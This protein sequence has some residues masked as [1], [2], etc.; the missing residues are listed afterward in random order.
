MRTG[1]NLILDGLLRYNVDTVIGIPGGPTVPFLDRLSSSRVKWVNGTNEMNAGFMA[2]GWSRARGTPGVICVTSGPGLAMTVNPVKNAF[3]E[4]YPLLIIAPLVVGKDPSQWQYLASNAFE[5][6]TNGIFQNT[7]CEEL[8][9]NIDKALQLTISG[10]DNRPYPG[11]V[12]FLV[13]P[14]LFSQSAKELHIKVE[15]KESKPLLDLGVIS[16]YQGKKICLLLGGEVDTPENRELANRLSKKWNAPVVHTWKGK[17]IVDDVGMV[18]SL[19]S[20]AANYATL[21]SDLVI[22]IGNYSFSIEK[23]FYYNRFGLALVGGKRLLVSF[24]DDGRIPERTIVVKG[25]A[26]QALETLL[27]MELRS[28]P[29]EWVE[30]ISEFKSLTE[31]LPR[32]PVK[33][34]WTT[35]RAMGMLS[36]VVERDVVVTG[37]GNH[38]YSAGKYLTPRK[39]LS[40]TNWASIGSGYPVGLGYAMAGD[41]DVWIVEGDGGL[42]FN[43]SVFLERY[44]ENI[45]DKNVKI[46]LIRDRKYGAIESVFQMDKLTNDESASLGEY[47][48]FSVEKMCDLFSIGYHRVSSPAEWNSCLSRKEK[49]VVLFELEVDDNS[50]YEID[51]TPEYERALLEKDLVYLSD[52]AKVYVIAS[53]DVL[54]EAKNFSVP[55]NKMVSETRIVLADIVAALHL[56]LLFYVIWAAAFGAAKHAWIPIF[57][58]A[59][60]YFD[61]GLD[62]KGRCIITVIEDRLRG[63]TSDSS[64]VNNIQKFFT[65]KDITS[66]QVDRILQVTYS[67]LTFIALYRFK[68]HCDKKK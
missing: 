39:W 27:S 35:E 7:T 12:L 66:A 34:E 67:I 63:Y 64:F 2:Q 46:V 51:L 10:T 57:L 28:V 19:G 1:S 48:E 5:T 62:S 8:A 58:I 25:S 54:E 47:G 17:G 61:W 20:H 50:V 60:M 11:P 26:N 56:F 4:H 45:R 44:Q 33:K 9:E 6:F 30:E 13:A 23:E 43:L 55:T 49:G 21:T 3:D 29:T 41:D 37:V 53:A 15:K 22:E 59:L 42:V 38:W 14:P 68:K 16:P 40:W 18:G 32:T 24:M 65:H 31:S 52:V 36:P